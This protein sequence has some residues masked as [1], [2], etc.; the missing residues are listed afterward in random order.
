MICIRSGCKVYKIIT[1][2]AVCGEFPFSSLEM[3]GRWQDYAKI[4]VKSTKS[5]VVRNTH[6]ETNLKVARLL[7]V[8]GKRNNRTIRLSRFS[9]PVLDWFGLK[10]YYETNFND[11]FS[12][13]KTHINRRQRV[14]ESFVAFMRAGI[15]SRPFKLPELNYRVIEPVIKSPSF[16]V[17]KEI[18]RV[19]GNDQKKIKYSRFVGLYCSENEGY[20]VYNSQSSVMKWMGRDEF[21]SKENIERVVRLNSAIQEI[22]T[23]ILLG[24]D[25]N[26]ASSTLKN[27]A[28]NRRKEFRF[29]GVF[30]HIL[31]IPLSDCGIRQL[32]I[33]QCAGWREKILDALFES[34]DRSYNRGAFE[35]DAKV[36]G[37]YVLSFL[38]GDIVRL[39]KFRNETLDDDD[40]KFEVVCYPFQTDFL[41]D[42]LGK[43]VKLTEI[44]LDAVERALE[45]SYR[46]KYEE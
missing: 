18:K 29:D 28:A 25:Y 34:E 13:G 9:A 30:E 7:T 43:D 12:S 20:V 14:A 35:Y 4:I 15:E 19:W 26:I 31:F 42:Y 33:T 11:N 17:A 41:C 32:A 39:A 16:F 46:D 1:T 6:T 23:A 44:E 5:Q 22:D 2:L 8:S 37:V 45:V 36:N 24:K 40:R 27:L 3:F 10:N 21:R 38:D